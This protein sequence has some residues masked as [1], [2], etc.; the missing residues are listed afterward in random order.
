MINDHIAM[1]IKNI[2]LQNTAICGDSKLS[3]ILPG[4]IIMNLIQI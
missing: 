3:E 1:C 4:G 2:E